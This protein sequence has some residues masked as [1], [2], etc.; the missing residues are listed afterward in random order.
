MYFL[1]LKRSIEMITLTNEDK[2]LL[3]HEVNKHF[4]D[5][6]P[7]YLANFDLEVLEEVEERLDDY[8]STGSF[9]SEYLWVYL[10]HLDFSSLHFSNLEGFVNY[11]EK[12]IAICDACLKDSKV[13]DNLLALII[14]YRYK[15]SL[16]F[17]GLCQGREN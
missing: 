6:T 7:E 15:V 1:T 13:A 8:E 5:S 10:D 4:R 3:I 16:G 17:E 12:S 11:Y 14:K 2:M 9:L